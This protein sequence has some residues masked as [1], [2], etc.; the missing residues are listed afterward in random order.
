[1]KIAAIV[2]LGLWSA[3]TAP[4]TPSTVAPIPQAIFRPP[5]PPPSPPPT[6]RSA[7]KLQPSG[8]PLLPWGNVPTYELDVR[9]QTPSDFSVDVECRRRDLTYPALDSDGLVLDITSKGGPLHLRV[10]AAADN[11]GLS[12][13]PCEPY[14]FAVLSFQLSSPL[15]GSLEPYIVTAS[16][17]RPFTVSSAS[18]ILVTDVPRRIGESVGSRYV[19]IEAPG[20]GGIRTGE[21]FRYT[22]RNG[23]DERVFVSLDD[24]HNVLTGA[25]NDPNDGLGPVFDGPDV[26]KLRKEYL[27]VPVATRNFE[28]TCYNAK[29]ERARVKLLAGKHLRI[30]TIVRAAHEMRWLPNDP[31]RPVFGYPCNGRCSEKSGT[32]VDSPIVVAMQLDPDSVEVIGATVIT[33]PSAWSGNCIG[34][35]VIL[36]NGT[37]FRDVFVRPT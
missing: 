12:A 22:G 1:M 34:G 5:S 33:R 20:L 27:N 19:G 37:Q 21:L 17:V 7:E 25:D 30:V 13:H 15:A 8:P 2:A 16:T 4:P 24:E 10:P 23:N 3:S 11:H 14:P 28:F 35:Y 36:Q 9:P 6:S 26:A 31:R 29:Q 18:D 32:F